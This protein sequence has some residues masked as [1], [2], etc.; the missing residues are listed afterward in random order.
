MPGFKHTFFILKIVSKT[1]IVNQIIT[2]HKEIYNLFGSGIHH[3]PCS[4]LR[5]KS[6][7][8]HNSN[9][10]IFIENDTLIY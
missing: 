7:V 6:H 8:L 3:E 2:Y 1:T 4:I 5:L 9:V 10:G